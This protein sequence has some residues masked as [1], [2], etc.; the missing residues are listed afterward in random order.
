[1][2]IITGSAGFIGS[3]LLYELNKR[4]RTDVIIVD[5]LNHDEKEHN[6]GPLRYE[7]LIS[8]ADFR[9]KLLTDDL[10]CDVEAIFHLGACADTTETNWEFLSDNNVEYSKDI[11]RWCVDHNARCVYASS[12]AVYGDG[13][14]GFSD[15][16]NLF[17]QLQP[18]NLYGKSKLDV[19]VWARDA[20]Y[21]DQIA[22]VRYFNVYGPNEWHKGDMRSVIAKKFD[23]AQKHGHIELFKSYLPKYKHGEQERDFIYVK[24]AVAATLHL[25]DQP[26]ANGVFNVGLGR[27]HT[28][29]EVAEGLAAGLKKK[30][31]IKYVPMPVQLRQ[32]YQYHTKADISKLKESG[33]KA[34]FTPL[35]GA[36]KEYV[37]K[38]LSPHLHLGE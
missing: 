4:G 7:R 33:F 36:I 32:Q 22:A 6:I 18:L 31:E 34:A 28:W 10:Q 38:H 14:Q 17:D 9:Q 12:A 25:F 2:I 3:A 15:D 19:D 8:I 27:A 21:L 11:I 1:M 20:G 26:E 29:N 5:E 37:Q 24:D 16:H 23:Q 30:V 13:K 35:K